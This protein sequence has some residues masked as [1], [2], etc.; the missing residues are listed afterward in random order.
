M[1][2]KSEETS[3]ADDDVSTYVDDVYS[4]LVRLFVLGASVVSIVV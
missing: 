4:V 3:I 2:D 1:V